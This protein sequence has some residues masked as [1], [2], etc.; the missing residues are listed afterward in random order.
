MRRFFGRIKYMEQKGFTLIELLVVVAIIGVI[1]SIVLV[2]LSGQ[3]EKATLARGQ[4]FSQS[5][6]N[7]LGAE[8]IG[9]WSFDKIEAG[10]TVIDVSGFN[11]NGIV[12]GA[13]P[14]QGIMRQALSFDGTINTYMIKNP[15]RN[16][17]STEITV[18]FWMK[19]PSSPAKNGT[20]FSYGGGN[21]FLIYNYNN[22]EIYIGGMGRATGVSANDNNWHH[23]AVV[24]K[25]AGGNVT[26]YKD[27]KIAYSG[28]NFRSGYPIINGRS[29][30]LGQEQDS[31]GGGFDASQ[32]FLGLLD[33]VRIYGQVLD[34][35][36]I[37]KHYAEGLEK[38]QL[39]KK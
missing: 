2:N 16:F 3:R 26:V 10:N 7:S 30:V 4:Q 35:A 25:S 34:S 36:E 8:A 13:I 27:G 5:I 9:I 17:P 14:V 24:W 20:P 31:E 23:I 18:E 19:S 12:Y 37:Q 11:N 29:L 22:F 33:E 39:V 38:Y 28:N 6:N 32:A 21:E 1:A 15:I